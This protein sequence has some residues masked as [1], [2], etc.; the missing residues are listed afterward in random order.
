MQEK[1]LFSRQGKKDNDAGNESELEPIG[2]EME[3]TK[4]DNE[5]RRSIPQDQ[6]NV[7]G[8]D[9]ESAVPLSSIGDVSG[10]VRFSTNEKRL[11]DEPLTDSDEIELADEL[12][13][14]HE[15]D[16]NEE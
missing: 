12:P 8:Q 11:A 1:K 7:H 9:E 16:V 13:T 10:S 3:E 2:T 14:E 6:N 4:D 15:L 5:R